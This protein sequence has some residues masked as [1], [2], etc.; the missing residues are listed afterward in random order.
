M[1]ITP[2]VV[3]HR[4]R[5]S[6]RCAARQLPALR[7]HLA[8]VAVRVTLHLGDATA[9][10][11]IDGLSLDGHGDGR[12]HAA[13]VMTAD[14]TGFLS[15]VKFLRGEC[16]R[17]R[18]IRRGRIAAIRRRR[19]QGIDSRGTR[20]NRCGE[21][22]SGLRPSTAT[23]ASAA[24]AAA[25][26]ALAATATATASEK[27]KRRKGNDREPSAGAAEAKRP[28]HPR[29][30]LSGRYVVAVWLR[31]SRFAVILGNGNMPASAF[32]ARSGPVCR[33]NSRAEER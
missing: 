14:R 33:R 22:I 19:R 27:Y 23:A 1:R 30:S 29:T 24:T 15:S 32:V 10:A 3:E 20:S 11:D 4:A 16:G 5:E 9:T 6:S 21:R 12:P 25:T 28:C 17:R 7:F 26:V 8:Q 18:S 31:G 2:W 13:Q